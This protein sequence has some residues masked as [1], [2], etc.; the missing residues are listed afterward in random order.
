MP[1]DLESGSPFGRSVVAM[2]IYLRCGRD[3]AYE[4]LSLLFAHLSSACRSAKTRSPI[5]SGAPS[6]FK[7]S[8]SEIHGTLRPSRMICSD[9]TSARVEGRN[10]LEWVFSRR[11]LPF[12]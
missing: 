12:M 5:C 1:A 4:R 8:A 10:H 7:D 6:A 2:A 11:A 9:E 3:I